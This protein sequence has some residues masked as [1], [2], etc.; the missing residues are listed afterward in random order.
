MIVSVCALSVELGFF[1]G[2]SHFVKFKEVETFALVFFLPYKII[3][4]ISG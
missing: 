4:S 2:S 1:A 3:A